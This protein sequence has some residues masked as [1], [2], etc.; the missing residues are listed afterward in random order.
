[1]TYVSAE[2]ELKQDRMLLFACAAIWL[3]VLG[4][5][6]AATV[7]LVDLGRGHPA[8]SGTSDTPWL[9]YSVI[10]AS[11]L[12][13]AGSIPLLLRARRAALADPRAGRGA[14]IRPAAGQSFPTAARPALTAQ[15]EAPTARVRA[16]GTRS[17]YPSPSAR[18]TF[19][20]ALPAAVDRLWLRCAVV[21]ACA[22]GVA[23]LAV[24]VATYLM[25]V[26]NDGPAWIAYGA[27]GLVTLAMPVVPLFF[28][29]QLRELLD[30]SGY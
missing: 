4:S 24:G 22:M 30:A 20:A 10:A 28:L 21:L 9:L 29:R 8:S 13:I 25:A 2:A 14:A 27:A 26:G 6:V 15:R 11:A 19:D 23:L 5:G 18:S 17:A 3:A 1:M 16:F 7:A 12:V